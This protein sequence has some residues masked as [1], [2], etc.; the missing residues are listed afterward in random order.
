MVGIETIM[1]RIMVEKLG[2]RN[3]I[4]RKN[5]QGCADNRLARLCET[6]KR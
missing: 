3:K 1:M 6:C 4:L 5:R 2:L